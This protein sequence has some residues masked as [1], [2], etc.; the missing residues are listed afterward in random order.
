MI[1]TGVA[2]PRAHGQEITNTAIALVIAKFKS[3]PIINHPTK[4]IRAITITVGTK[5]LTTLSIVLVIGALELDASST[6]SIILANVLSSTVLVTVYIKVPRRLF[7]PPITKL[8][9]SFSIGRLSPVIIDS[10]IELNP[11]TILPSTGTVSFALTRTRSSIFNSEI[12]TISSLPSLKRQATSGAN[13]NNF[14]IASVVFFFDLAPRY[15]PKLINVTII[16]ADS[17]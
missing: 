15:F 1:A 16:P 4:V 2:K 5:Y 6:N 8:L 3:S 14:P 11:C 7:V 17:K 9:T 12:L 13:S 10:S